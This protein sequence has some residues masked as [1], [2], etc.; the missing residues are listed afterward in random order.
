MVKSLKGKGE[1]ILLFL[2][3]ASFYIFLQTKSIYGGDSGDLVTAAWLNGIPHPPGY[4]FYSLL[5]YLVSHLIPFYTPAWRVGL[6]SSIPT[7]LTVTFFYLLLRKIFVKRKLSA[8]IATLILAFV[9][10]FWLSAEIVEVF[11]LNNLLVIL[12]IY[13]TFSLLQNHKIQ[14]RFLFVLSFI[15]GL[16]LAHHH[17]V[18]LIFPGLIFLFWQNKKKM[19]KLVKY[20]KWRMTLFFLLGFSFYLYPLLICRQ[21]QIV[22][23]DNPVNLKNLL[24]LIS[25]ADYGS[26]KVGANLGNTPLFRVYSLLAFGRLFLLDFSWMG[27]GLLVLGLWQLWKKKRNLFYFLGINLL[28]CLFFI[29]YASFLLTNDFMMATF[30]RFLLLPYIFAG[31]ILSL[32]VDFILIELP[33]GLEKI[34]LS[35]VSRRVALIGVKI[36][37]LILPLSLLIANFRKIYPLRNDFSAEQLAK[38]F[39]DSLPEN[40]ILMMSSDTTF[41][42]ALYVRYVLGYRKDVTV[43]GYHLMPAA[44][45]QQMIRH[46]FPEIKVSEKTESKENFKE[47][48]ELNSPNFAIFC[49]A[50]S[51]EPWEDWS[52]YGLALQYQ[53]LD[54]QPE[55]EKTI[56]LNQKI[57]AGLIEPED[58]QA[59]VYKNLFLADIFRT[60]EQARINFG[61][62]LL[63]HDHFSE[64]EEV[65][66]QAEKLN[67]QSQE[68]YMGLG[69]SA[70]YQQDCSKA[71][72]MFLQ[73]LEINKENSLAL[74]YLRRNALECFDN[75]DEAKIFESECVQ[76]EQNKGTNLD[77]LGQ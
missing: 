67:P 19:L 31:L 74:G 1:G 8:L 27:V 62:L 30:E 69:I 50:Y 36:I 77:T 54:Q 11:A 66:T 43:L 22:C 61:E 35:L 5:A 48:V 34:K 59:L 46:N 64:A 70:F 72:A 18:V 9:Y 17:L 25:R 40:S 13:I 51:F 56:A 16:A 21:N 49:D 39:M 76:I 6:L 52:P 45:Y 44:Y 55:A 7:A 33:S 41:F 68:V 14:K 20:D 47:F 2:L 71:K 12:L 73:V 65:F 29:F 42:N 3:F 23:W 32:G 24:V 37:L 38:N 63:N 15:L 75:P 10:P 28:T 4:P 26:F 57:W 58:R 60:Y 53:P